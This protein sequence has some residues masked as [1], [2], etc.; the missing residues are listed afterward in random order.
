MEFIGQSEVRDQTF[1]FDVS[2]RALYVPELHQREGI[3]LIYSLLFFF[4]SFSQTFY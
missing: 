1:D 3:T 4:T 2:F